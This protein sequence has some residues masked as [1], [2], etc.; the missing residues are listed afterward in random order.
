MTS[1]VRSISSACSSCILKWSLSSLCTAILNRVSWPV[2]LHGLLTRFPVQVDLRLFCSEP[3]VA[4]QHAWPQ[5]HRR[6]GLQGGPAR[7]GSCLCSPVCAAA[8]PADRPPA[9]SQPPFRSCELALA[10]PGSALRSRP[11][12]DRSV[13]AQTPPLQG[14]PPWPLC[15]T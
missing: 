3:L 7:P 14:A 11:A 15:L 1:P 2:S 10:A 4:S 9:P 5:V 12:P 6:A 13:S 8:R